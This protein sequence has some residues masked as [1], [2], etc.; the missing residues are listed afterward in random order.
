MFARLDILPGDGYVAAL[1]HLIGATDWEGLLLA[2]NQLEDARAR[3]LRERLAIIY[4]TM[5]AT[6]VAGS[7]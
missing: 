7:A 4:R 6:E 5:E 1:P 3:E 2:R